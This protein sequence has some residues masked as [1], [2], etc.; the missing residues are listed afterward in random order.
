MK[1]DTLSFLWRFH[2]ENSLKIVWEFYGENMENLITRK[3]SMEI[4]WRWCGE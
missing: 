2:D 4:V 1:R 3:V